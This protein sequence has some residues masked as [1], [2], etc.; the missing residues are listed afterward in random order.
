MG[1]VCTNQAMTVKALRKVT[2][3]DE[4]YSVAFNLNGSSGENTSSY[5]QSKGYYV[6]IAVCLI[7]P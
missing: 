5:C 2:N 4:V 3:C 6:Y 7:L 1:H